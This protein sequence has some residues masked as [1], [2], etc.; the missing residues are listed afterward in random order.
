[1]QINMT[2]AMDAVDG[3]VE[4]L[5]EV[6]TDVVEEVPGQLN[7]LRDSLQSNNARK[8]EQRAHYLK[9]SLGI[10][11]AESASKLAA[12]LEM[13]GR[14]KEFENTDRLIDSL[15]HELNQLKQ[16]FSQPDWEQRV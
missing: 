9:G 3:D 5:K 12:E 10:I 13:L 7:E 8:L 4:L 11:G 16:F 2:W 15:E 1:M 6:I 14:R